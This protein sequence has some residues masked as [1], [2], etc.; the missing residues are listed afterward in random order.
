MASFQPAKCITACLALFFFASRIVSAEPPNFCRGQGANPAVY[1]FSLGSTQAAVI[2]DGDIEVPTTFLS[3]P[4]LAAR[5]L[6]RNFRLGD[7][8]DAV[9]SFS[10]NTLYLKRPDGTQIIIDTGGGSSTAM[11]GFQVENLKAAG[12]RPEDINVVLISHGHFDHLGNIVGENG[13]LTYPN[14]RHYISRVE[15]QFYTTDPVNLDALRLPDGFTQTFI[16]VAQRNLRGIPRE[17]LRLFEFWDEV[18]PGIQ[19][20][21]TTYHSPGHVSFKIRDGNNV[22]LYLGDALVEKSISVSNPWFRF[23]TETDPE[24]GVTG[25]AELLTSLAAQRTTILMYHE[26]FPGL[27]NIGETEFAWDFKPIGYASKSGVRTIC[28]AP[29]YKK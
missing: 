28:P 5:A 1:H 13:T 16:E 27:G 29:G 11:G 9:A 25:R 19:A 15:F 14:A 23:G 8:P 24:R 26:A 17:K 4:S 6:R 7:G 12:I 22:L 20:I 10:L 18:L 21:P 3:E 2:S